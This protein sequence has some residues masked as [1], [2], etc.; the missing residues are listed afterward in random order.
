LGEGAT[1]RERAKEIEEAMQR[2]KTERS[3]QAIERSSQAPKEAM[4]KRKTEL[5]SHTSSKKGWGK[6]KNKMEKV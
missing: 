2:R 6:H 1:E 5:S 3:S 4:Q